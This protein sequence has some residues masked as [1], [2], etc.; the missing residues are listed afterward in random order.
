MI[1]KERF[2]RKV[3]TSAGPDGCW[4]WTGGQCRSGKDKIYGRFHNQLTHRLAYEF[5]YGPIPNGLQ[6]DHRCHNTLCVNP[7]HLRP[8]T[9]KQNKENRQ[10]AHGRSGVRGVHQVGNRW[11]ACVVHNRKYIHV[12]YFST[13]EEAGEAARLKR[14]EL[15]THNDMD[16]RADSLRSI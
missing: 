8:V 11:R 7:R 13:S 14:N 9:G 3:D 15:F 2:D 6:V 1:R 16:R 4:L 10:G 5:E 12:G